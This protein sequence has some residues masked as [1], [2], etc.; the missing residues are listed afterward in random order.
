MTILI[1]FSVILGIGAGYFFI[2][3]S[4]LFYSDIIST[5]SLSLL[6]FLVGI[7]LGQNIHIFK[8]LKKHGSFLL[9][10]PFSIIAGSSLGGLVTGWIF[11]IPL[12][13][14]LSISS[15]FG[16]YSLSGVLLKQLVNAE[17]GAI[18]FLTNVLRELLAVIS[19]PFIAKYLNSY[20][21]IA[22][23]G[24]TSMDTTLPIISKYSGSEIVVI[25]FFNGALL[26]TLVPILVS[27]FYY[28]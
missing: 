15:G 25:A 7:D 10:I 24:A 5:I 3:Q 20:S 12:N 17:I 8:E 13:I 2:P 1:L 22:P 28:L 9:L 26:S 27:F 19:I 21:T 11:N 16:W 14:S 23:A 18:A 6:L 4:F